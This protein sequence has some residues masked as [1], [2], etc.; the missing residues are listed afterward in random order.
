MAQ[1][2]GVTSKKVLPNP[3]SQRFSEPFRFILTELIWTLDEA[4]L[5]FLSLG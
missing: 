2:F 5:S 1:D 3:R 4:F